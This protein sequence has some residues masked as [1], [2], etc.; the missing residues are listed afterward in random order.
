MWLLATDRGQYLGKIKTIALRN[1]IMYKVLKDQEEEL[2]KVINKKP[3]Q[4]V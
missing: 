3:E 4:N 2:K 1:A